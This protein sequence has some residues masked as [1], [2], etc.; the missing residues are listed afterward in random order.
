MDEIGQVRCHKGV[1]EAPI[2]ENHGNPAMSVGVDTGNDDHGRT[3]TSMQ[4]LRLTHPGLEFWID[5]QLRE[6]KQGWIAEA[7][8]AGEREI[9]VGRDMKTAIRRAP[10]SL[11]DQRAKEMAATAAVDS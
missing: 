4:R 6:Y 1:V 9:G 7:D 10:V 11:G 8:L 3:M 5:V 2:P